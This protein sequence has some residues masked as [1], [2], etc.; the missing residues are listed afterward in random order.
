MK[1]LL[2]VLV[3]AVVACGVRAADPAQA[4]ASKARRVGIEEYE[5][6][7]TKTNTVLLDVRSPAEFEKGHIP[8]AINIDINSTQFTEKVSALDKGKTYLVNCAVGMR[9]ARA[10]Q[11]LTTLGFTNLVDLAPGFDGWKKAGKPVQK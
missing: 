8:G 5:Q 7:R 2:A 10:C 6:F 3:M 1:K 11:K 9:S 4:Q